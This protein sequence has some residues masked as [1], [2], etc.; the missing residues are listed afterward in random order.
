ML[1]II[2]G[3][4][5][6]ATFHVAIIS[7]NDTLS[8]VRCI[9]SNLVI[10]TPGSRGKWIFCS[11]ASQGVIIGIVATVDIDALGRAIH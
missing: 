9:G 11:A 2:I 1:G 10:I 8:Q 3:I 5:S 6:L 7:L 4:A